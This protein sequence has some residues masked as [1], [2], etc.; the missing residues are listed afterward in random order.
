MNKKY[1]LANNPKFKKAIE[2]VDN[3][4]KKWMECQ[5]KMGCQ[6]K[7][8]CRKL[9]QKFQKANKELRKILTESYGWA[10][11]KTGW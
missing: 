1:P 6:A 3:T 10:I 11:K 4:H 5:T 9:K 7:K 2:K 8:E